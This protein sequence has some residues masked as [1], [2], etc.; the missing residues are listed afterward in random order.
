MFEIILLFIGK[1]IRIIARKLRTM[2]AMIHDFLKVLM[3]E[4]RVK[5]DAKL[6]T[7]VLKKL[8]YA[9]G[10]RRTH[11]YVELSLMMLNEKGTP[12]GMPSFRIC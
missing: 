2:K 12:E 7:K 9:R 11:C 6:R 1:W 3:I 8:F 5:K 10:F 4:P